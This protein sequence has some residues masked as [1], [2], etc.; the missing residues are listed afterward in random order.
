VRANEIMLM[1]Q[2][3][4]MPPPAPVTITTLPETMPL[5]EADSCAAAD[6]AWKTVP[7]QPVWFTG[8]PHGRF[9]KA[10]AEFKIRNAPLLRGGT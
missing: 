7:H 1:S 8:M 9:G 6:A 10:F 5:I 3:R 4:P 2:P